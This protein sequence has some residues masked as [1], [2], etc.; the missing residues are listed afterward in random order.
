LF[1]YSAQR[2][3][4]ASKS[5]KHDINRMSKKEFPFHKRVSVHIHWFAPRQLMSS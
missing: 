2:V 5:W 3:A 1:N 4:L